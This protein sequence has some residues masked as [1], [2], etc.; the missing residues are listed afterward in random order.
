MGLFDKIDSKTVSGPTPKFSKVRLPAILAGMDIGHQVDDDGDVMAD[1]DNLRVFFE[2]GGEDGEILVLRSAWDFRPALETHAQLL[3]WLNEWNVSHYWPRIGAI[4]GEEQ[5]IVVTDLVVDLE[6]GATDDFI[7]QQ[8]RC[9]LTTSFQA[10]EELEGAFP[11]H[12]QW[13][14]VGEA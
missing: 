8:I 3:P 9:F 13:H 4:Q 2:S 10:Y 11:E 12:K 1:W 14:N 5:C 7:R 6:F